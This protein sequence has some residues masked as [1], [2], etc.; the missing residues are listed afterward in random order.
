MRTFYMPLHRFT[1][2][3]SRNKFGTDRQTDRQ[4]EGQTEGQTDIIVYCL[5]LYSLLHSPICKLKVC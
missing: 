1:L 4:T 3:F 5:K 2:T